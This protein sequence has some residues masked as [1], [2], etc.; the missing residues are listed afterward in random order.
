MLSTRGTGKLYR[1]IWHIMA[2]LSYLTGILPKPKPR[3]VILLL[4]LSTLFGLSMDD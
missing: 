3:H 4:S 2:G 1:H